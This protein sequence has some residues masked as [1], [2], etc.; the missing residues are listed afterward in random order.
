MAVLTP[1]SLPGRSFNLHAPAPLDALLSIGRP[2]GIILPMLRCYQEFGHDPDKKEL[3][4]ID[5]PEKKKAY[6]KQRRDS[7]TSPGPVA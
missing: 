6:E 1:R 7:M 3:V 4:V 5:Y 2:D